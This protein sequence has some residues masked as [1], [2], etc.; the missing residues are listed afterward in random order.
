MVSSEDGLL[1]QAT[2]RGAVGIDAADSGLG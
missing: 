2:V 1:F